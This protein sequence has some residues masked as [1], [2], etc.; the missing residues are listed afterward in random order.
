MTAQEAASASWKSLKHYRWAAL[1]VAA[2]AGMAGLGLSF[3]DLAKLKDTGTWS[4]LSGVGMW[5]L[6]RAS[7]RTGAEVSDK[8]GAQQRKQL[9]SVQSA[10]NATAEALMDLT[11]EFR[12]SEKDRKAMHE[13]NHNDNRMIGNEVRQIRERVDQHGLRLDKLEKGRDESA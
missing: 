11:K 7:K 10:F 2:G 8:M 4:M 3:D 12:E 9:D 1:C 5:L 13:E 6:E